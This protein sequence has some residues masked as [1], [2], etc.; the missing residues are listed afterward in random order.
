M[1]VIRHYIDLSPTCQVFSIVPVEEDFEAQTGSLD[2]KIDGSNGDASVDNL[3]GGDDDGI[4]YG[5]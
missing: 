5:D 4:I 2:S 3:G 1:P